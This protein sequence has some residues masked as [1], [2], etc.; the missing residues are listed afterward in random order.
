L[1]RFRALGIDFSSYE[2]RKAGSAEMPD[3]NLSLSL[4]NARALQALDA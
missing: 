2:D 4:Q 3:A 1:T